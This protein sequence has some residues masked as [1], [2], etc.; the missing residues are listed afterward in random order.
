MPVGVT[1]AGANRH[2]HLL[3]AESLA[4]LIVRRRPQGLR[5]DKGYD[6][7]STRAVARRLRLTLHLRTRG[8]EARARR[9]GHQARRWVVE[10][11]HS[12]LTTLRRGRAGNHRPARPQH[13]AAA[14]IVVDPIPGYYSRISGSSP[15]RAGAPP[16]GALH[17][18]TR[19]D[20]RLGGALRNDASLFRH[21][22]NAPD[23]KLTIFQLIG[24][25]A[26][27]HWHSNPCRHVPFAN[28]PPNSAAKIF[29]AV[30]SG[31]KLYG[32]ALLPEN[33]IDHPTVI[34]TEDF[35]PV[36]PAQIGVENLA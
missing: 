25:L 35:S 4:G 17:G 19:I 16:S 14:H 1:V 23:A 9:R 2:D 10:R 8:V 33:F 31:L 5:L 15:P 7:A 24:A 12:W 32:I 22:E 29:Q 21:A 30:P 27:R 13:A 11:T 26:S 36:R 20:A 34:T 3:L 28:L 18:K 6:Y